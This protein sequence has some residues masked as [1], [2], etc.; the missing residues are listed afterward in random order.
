VTKFTLLQ[1]GWP[2][3]PLHSLCKPCK[4]LLQMALPIFSLLSSNR[5]GGAR[6]VFQAKAGESFALRVEITD[7]NPSASS[8]YL[9]RLDAWLRHC[10]LF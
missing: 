9:L 3:I 1:Q 2:S 6:P 4:L 7:T 8:G 5:R 10:A